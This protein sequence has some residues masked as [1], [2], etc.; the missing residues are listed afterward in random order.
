[1]A[2]SKPEEVVE[3]LEK[4][5]KLIGAISKKSSKLII[6]VFQAAEIIGGFAPGK[7][8]E[9]EALAAALI[10]HIK[11]NDANGI[12]SP[13]N[14]DEIIERLAVNRKHVQLL[15]RGRQAEYWEL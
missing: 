14:E 6:A 12:K 15:M 7:I 8:N 1:M 3:R 10:L 13:I 4:K 11:A 2:L 9:D 5:A